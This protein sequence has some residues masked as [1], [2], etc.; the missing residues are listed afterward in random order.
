[1]ANF[2]TE[3]WRVLR[4][5][6]EFIESIQ[7]MASAGTSVSVFGSSRLKPDT[8]YYKIGEQIGRLL[9]ARGISVIT[10]GGPGIMEAANKGAFQARSRKK[11]RSIGLN[12]EL[13]YEQAPNPFLSH[14]KNF[15][16][17]FIRKVMFVKYAKGVI[18]L[19]GGYGTMDEFFEVMT[20]IQTGK[21]KK[22]P[23]VLVGSSFW[24]PLISY[25]RGHILQAGLIEKI[26]MTIFTVV[27]TAEAAVQVMVKHIGRTTRSLT[28]NLKYARP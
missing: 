27:D 6:A 22:I 15:H 11:G 3:Q 18:I 21:I 16:Y 4:V 19:P 23:V 1:M 28:D 5:L 26:D 12:I 8:K 13:P 14:L 10:G 25:F 7:F 24:L 20:L 2:M 9:A 17:F